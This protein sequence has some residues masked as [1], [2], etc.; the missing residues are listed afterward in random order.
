MEITIDENRSHLLEASVIQVVLSLLEVYNDKV[1]AID[2][3]VAQLSTFELKL[4]RTALGALLNA[5][6]GYGTDLSLFVPLLVLIA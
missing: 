6:L 4:L 1:S 2:S 5:S 3:Q